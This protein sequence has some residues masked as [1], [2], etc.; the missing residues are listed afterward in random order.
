MT[1]LGRHNPQQVTVNQN[2]SNHSYLLGEAVAVVAVL[3]RV[4]VHGG[5]VRHTAAAGIS[6]GADEAQGFTRCD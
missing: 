6:V 2:R 1:L 4:V 3:L 5:D